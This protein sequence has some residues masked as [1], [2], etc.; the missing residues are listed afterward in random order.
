MNQEDEKEFSRS[1]RAPAQEGG[2]PAEP[3][4]AMAVARDWPEHSGKFFFGFGLVGQ[5]ERRTFYLK[6][7]SVTF[8]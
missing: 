5:K 4:M 2:S 8:E 1:E 7:R 3:W 6:K